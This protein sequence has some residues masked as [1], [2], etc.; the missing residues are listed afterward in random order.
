[1]FGSLPNAG[2]FLM[3]DNLEGFVEAL[4]KFIQK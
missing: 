4:A 2:H 1:L 3:F